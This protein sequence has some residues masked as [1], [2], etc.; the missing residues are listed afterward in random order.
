MSLTS[1]LK[2]ESM[3]GGEPVAHSNSTQPRDHKSLALEWVAPSPK[4]SGAI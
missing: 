2:D 3:K 4:S 1:L